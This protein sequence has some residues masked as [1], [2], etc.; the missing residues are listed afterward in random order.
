MAD[1]EQ[2]EA[3]RNFCVF[4]SKGG[5]YLKLTK[6]E[7]MAKKATDPGA[8]IVEQTESGAQQVDC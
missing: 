4:G 2:E 1:N 6:E 7:A 3:K 8:T 5:K